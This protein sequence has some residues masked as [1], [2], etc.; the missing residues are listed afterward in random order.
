MLW[1]AGGGAAVDTRDLKGM[2]ESLPQYRDQL[3]KLALHIDMASSMIDR[4]KGEELEEVGK[5]EQELVYGDATS[6]EL[7]KLLGSEGRAGMDSADKV[8]LLMCYVAT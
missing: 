2:V 5:L 4:L 6:K 7:I 1:K 8:R 3:R